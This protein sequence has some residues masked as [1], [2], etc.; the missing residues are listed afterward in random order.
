VC[1]E[2]SDQLI[3]LCSTTQHHA[4]RQCL[5]DMVLEQIRS[6]PLRLPPLTCCGR[7]PA[8]VTKRCP[9]ELSDVLVLQVLSPQQFVEYERVIVAAAFQ[10]PLP[11]QVI[12][13]SPCCKRPFEISRDDCRLVARVMP[14]PYA[15]R[16]TMCT[17][18]KRQLTSAELADVQQKQ[19]AG[20]A[21][22]PAATETNGDDLK[23][24]T[25]WL[26]SL[27]EPTQLN[28]VQSSE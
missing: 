14:C 4:C 17:G 27:D 18:C 25:E 22:A 11:R 13:W 20:T 6:T 9:L 16:A 8:D 3:Q 24:A 23:E 28:Q 10:R 19:L 15:C 2:P 12:L 1:L 7:L 5:V 21:P 26:Q